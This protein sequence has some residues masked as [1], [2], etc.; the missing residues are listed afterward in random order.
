[1]GRESEKESVSFSMSSPRLKKPRLNGDCNGTTTMTR[2]D[3][4]I[5]D[6]ERDKTFGDGTGGHDG[7]NGFLGI[8]DQDD[9]VLLP[10]TGDCKTG[11]GTSESKETESETAAESQTAETGT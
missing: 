4:L 11:T 2:E 3:T 6:E 10:P 7:S 9:Q 5:T 1:M 8:P